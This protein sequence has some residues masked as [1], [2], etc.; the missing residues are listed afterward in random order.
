M[1]NTI[2]IVIV[3]VILVLLCTATIISGYSY[4]MGYIELR[5]NVSYI[6]ELFRHKLCQKCRKK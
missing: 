4:T 2:I 5:K 3:H 6:K 1:Y